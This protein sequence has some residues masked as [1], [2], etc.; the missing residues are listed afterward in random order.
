MSRK[1]PGLGKGLDALIPM[2]DSFQPEVPSSGVEEIPIDEI[3]PNPRQP[4]SNF[5]PEELS[6][7]STSIQEHGIIQPLILTKESS[8]NF[9]LI[10]GERRLKAAKQ[11][12]LSTGPAIVREASEQDR[13]ELALIENVQRTDLNP[14][15][16]AKA[17]RQL[18]DEFS[19]SHGEIADRVGKSRVTI[20][21]TLRL[22]NL[23]PSVQQAL[24][25]N[26]ISEGH[27]RTLLSLPN[28][29][30][31]A[32]ALQTVIQKNLNVRQTEELVR[33]LVGEKPPQKSKPLPPPEIQALEE[34]L[35]VNLGTKVNLKHGKKGGTITI[36]YYSDEELD[37]LVER[38]MEEE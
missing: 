17:F 35:Q 38:F 14:L 23:P 8:G 28:P 1:R 2:G 30:S 36:H 29:Q 6:E 34:R 18:S 33:K 5:N 15:E 26:T 3:N 7:L 37:S 25:D 32:A 22:L 11:I 20:T 10:A 19:L 16:T 24:L 4:R 9:T 31:Q 12:G 27:A 13:L 21:N